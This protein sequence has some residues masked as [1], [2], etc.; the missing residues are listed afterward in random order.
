MIFGR[1]KGPTHEDALMASRS[2]MKRA[3][4]ELQFYCPHPEVRELADEAMAE[5]QRVYEDG[6]RKSVN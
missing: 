1:V 4:I 2:V 6:V 5:Q 3:L